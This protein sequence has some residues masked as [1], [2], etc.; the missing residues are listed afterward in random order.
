LGINQSI[1]IDMLSMPDLL[2]EPVRV[3]VQPLHHLTDIIFSNVFNEVLK[4]QNIL[5]TNGY[6]IGV[7]E[8][9]ALDSLMFKPG[10]PCPTLLTAV[11]GVARPQ[12]RWHVTV[13]YPFGYPTSYGY[14]YANEFG[15]QC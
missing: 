5:K 2:I 6:A 14:G 13:F 4:L 3:L 11:S 10:L 8:A 15:W 7:W 1:A 12:G 9:V